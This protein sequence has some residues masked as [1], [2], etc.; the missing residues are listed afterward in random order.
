[1]NDALLRYLAGLLLC[2]LIA[3]AYAATRKRG[4]R[5]IALDSVFCLGCMLT[6]IAAVAAAV[7]ILCSL[8]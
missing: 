1:V 4:L 7:Q 8:K 2:A 6:V 3:V 5:A